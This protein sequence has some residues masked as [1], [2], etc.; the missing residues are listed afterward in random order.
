[1]FFEKENLMR[2]NSVVF[3]ILLLSVI[4]LIVSIRETRHCKDEAQKFHEFALR[5]W[6]YDSLH[7]MEMVAS[8]HYPTW[9]EELVEARLAL[10][11]A[12]N[13]DELEVQCAIIVEQLAR[14]KSVAYTRE[15]EQNLETYTR[16]L[17]AR[18]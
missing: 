3:A 10:D 1:M 17:A 14:A 2:K 12:K 16:L 8:F 5:Y 15:I 7:T 9:K 13:F 18:R 4:S 11:G 6:A